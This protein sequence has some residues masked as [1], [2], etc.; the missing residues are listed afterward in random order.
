MADEQRTPRDG[1][2]FDVVMIGGGTGGYVAAIR[3]QQLG[4]DVAV[5]ETDKIGGTCLHR[6]CIPTNAFL[7]SADVY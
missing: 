2:A 4:L 6:G 3:A 1:Q 5:V 7:K